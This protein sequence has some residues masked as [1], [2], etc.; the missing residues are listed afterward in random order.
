MKHIEQIKRALQIGGVQS[1]SSSWVS[2]G[3][4][5]AQIDLLIDRADHC[6]NICE[7]KFSVKPFS[8]DKKYAAALKNK[9]MVFRQ[10]TDTRKTLLLTFIT[11]YGLAE[12]TYKEQLAGNEITMDALFL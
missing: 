5:G 8:I 4:N 10:Q 1:T 12:N 2:T 3:A 9:L 6:I 7:I 11:A